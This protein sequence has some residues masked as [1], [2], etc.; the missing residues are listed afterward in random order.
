MT[1]QLQ[2]EA[3][4]T[5]KPKRNGKRDVAKIAKH[6]LMGSRNHPSKLRRRMNG[7]LE[8]WP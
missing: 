5:A 6:P 7:S 1:E 8:R 3:P 4:E 2:I